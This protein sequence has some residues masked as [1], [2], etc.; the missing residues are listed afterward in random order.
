MGYRYIGSKARIVN[1]II[2]Y[3]GPPEDQNTYFIDAFCGTG[4]VAEKA[5]M[6]GWNVKLNDMMKYATVISNARLL[7]I[8]DVSFDIFGGYGA[9]LD[10]LNNIRPIKGFFWREYT[11]A[12]KKIVGI[13]RK[14]FTEENGSKIDAICQK[15]HHWKVQELISENEY[16]LLLAD[17]ISAVNSVAN[18]A[19]TYGCFLSKW[20]SQALKSIELTKRELHKDALR[21]ESYNL[22]VTKFSYLPND[23]VYLDPPYTKRQYASYYHI[24]ETIVEGDEPV[25]EGVSGLRPW[26]KNASVFCYK[27]KALNALVEL[28]SNMNVNRVLLSYSN[29]GHV[30]IRALVDHLS[31]TGTV[32]IEEI[33]IIGRYRPN[34]M[35]GENKSEVSE[36]LIDYRRNDGGKK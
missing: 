30:P 35:A 12:S 8:S 32:N 36:Y 6:A 17:L 22:D 25:V 24:L 21:F 14:Y 29:D 27:A 1:E 31:K 28:I 34:K 7:A 20:T 18:I 19:G 15:I 2:K 13:E 33:Q 11:P 23:V 16:V 3:L 4:V 5:A 26:K 10:Y 9:T